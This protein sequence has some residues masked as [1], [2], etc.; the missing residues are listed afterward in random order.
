[1]PW[2][3]LA[4]LVIVLISAPQLWVRHVLARYNRKPE[5]NFPG[6]G[7]ELARHLLNRYQLSQVQ[8][9]RS[10]LGDYYDPRRPAVHLTPDKFEGSTLTAIATAAHEVGH[11]IQHHS[12]YRPF[13]LRERLAKAAMLAQKLGSF[14]LFAA[15]LLTL[16]SRTPSVGL[17]TAVGAFA[18][19]GSNLLLQMITL[20]LEIDASFRRALPLLLAG[21][22]ITPE[23]EPAVRR[24][25]R[26]CAYTYVA[27]ALSNLLNFWYWL[28]VFRR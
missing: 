18:V 12:G 28:R 11:A 2:I 27:A 8:V 13:I 22:Y 24:I 15:P 17:I 19:M 10:E 25:L 14:L 16:A 1:M 21:D 5:E 26:A 20:P 6:N 7:A 9:E 23:Q 4:L 3:I